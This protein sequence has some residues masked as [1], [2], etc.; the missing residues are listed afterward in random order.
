VSNKIGCSW[1]KESKKGHEITNPLMDDKK[2][3]ND[4]DDD[5]E[6]QESDCITCFDDETREKDSKDFLGL[7]SSQVSFILFLSVSFSLPS[8]SDFKC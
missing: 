3:E 6:Q 8:S 2:L 4:V 1:I 7:V 5:D